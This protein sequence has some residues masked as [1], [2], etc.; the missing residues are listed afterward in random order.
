MS[1][2][3]MDDLGNSNGDAQIVVP[4]SPEERNLHPSS[5]DMSVLLREKQ[6]G[7]PIHRY[8]L[9]SR[10]YKPEFQTIIEE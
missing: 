3:P 1:S 5:K 4:A 9:R 2:N 8:S 10:G 6:T 7:K